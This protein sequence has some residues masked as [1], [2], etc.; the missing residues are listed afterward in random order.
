MKKKLFTTVATLALSAT[1]LLS[2]A[3]CST[4]NG[5][6]QNAAKTQTFETS[7]DFFA[8]S[9]V[10]GA[11]FLDA[12]P[13][14]TADNLKAETATA[15]PTEFTGE[16][17]KEI[18]N[19]LVMFDSVV[20]GGITFNVAECSDA[21]GDFAAYD[22]KMTVNFNTDNATL[23]YNETGV[24]TETDDDD[25]DEGK[26]ETETTLKGVLVSGERK[27]DAIGKREEESSL[28]ENEFELELLIKKSEKTYVKF[29]YSTESEKGENETE[30]ECEIYE[31][32][33]KIQETE[34]EIEEENGL[35]EIKFEFKNNGTSDGVEYK[36]VKRSENK[37]DIKR[38]QNGK[39]SYIL[40]EKTADGYK[41]T[42]SNGFFET[43]N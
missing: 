35:T 19:T 5:G 41:F 34:I 20:G 10:F 2:V 42:Y 18:K 12:V 17:V 38:E 23:Y 40:A 14:N 32:G 43:L 8:A 21:D 36:I 16:N 30:Y 31:N 9:A 25:D 29:T 39:K 22:Y 28:T 3:A 4:K 27:Y 7:K 26:T 33:K 1:L 6:N 11:N 15:R 13:E 37:F 24:K